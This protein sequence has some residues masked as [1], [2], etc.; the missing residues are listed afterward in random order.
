MSSSLSM[1][2]LALSFILQT[3]FRSLHG[4]AETHSDTKCDLRTIQYRDYKKM[5]DKA[6]IHFKFQ[7]AFQAKNP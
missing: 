2:L 5:K 6:S 3:E 4:R 1:A 7:F